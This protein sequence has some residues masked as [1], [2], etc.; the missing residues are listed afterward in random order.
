PPSCTSPGCLDLT[1]HISD[2]FTHA[3]EFIRDLDHH[4]HRE[5]SS[6]GVVFC[7]LSD[8]RALPRVQLRFACFLLPWLLSPMDGGPAAQ[9]GNH[10]RII[11]LSLQVEVV[12][13]IFFGVAVAISTNH[14]DLL[15]AQL[16]S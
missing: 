2:G 5:V 16:V 11:A 10:T 14:P 7:S 3:L 8:G 6:I 15:T 9:D 12:G 4:L 1:E 13:Q